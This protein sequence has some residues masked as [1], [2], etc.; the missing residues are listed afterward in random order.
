MG[1]FTS[2][3]ATT[4]FSFIATALLVGGLLAGCGAQQIVPDAAHGF[5]ARRFE[6]RGYQVYRPRNWTAD[7]KWP[8]IVYLHGGGE[9]GRDGVASAAVGLGPAVHRANGQLPFVVIFPQAQRPWPFPEEEAR[10]LS[11]VDA[12]IRDEA[13]DPD[14]VYLTGNSMGGFGTWIIGARHPERFA[15]LA[16]FCG[17]VRPPRGVRV[18]SD[19]FSNQPDPEAAVARAL[20]RMPVWAFHGGR[21]WVAS[22]ES[23]R[24]L[25]AAMR[26]A[27]GDITYTEYPD[28]GHDAWDRAYA[29]PKLY[30]WLLAHVRRGSSGGA[31]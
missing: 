28:L 8:L 2:L 27:G 17:G 26:A 3:H 20:G 1:R 15:A 9:R 16:P 11:I 31:P 12:A 4:K 7:K 22:P 5:S 13:G 21:D 23:S 24:R 30:E 10:L 6:G 29:D 14:R 19:S 25:V 18:T